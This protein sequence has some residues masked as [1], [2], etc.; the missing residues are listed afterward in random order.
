MATGDKQEWT[1]EDVQNHF[2]TWRVKRPKPKR[3]PDELW[4]EAVGLLSENT[5]TKVAKALRLEGR[6]LKAK[7]VK[8]GVVV[9][10][11]RKGKAAKPAVPTFLVT[12]VEDVVGKERQAQA[13]WKVSIKRSD[14]L[15]MAIDGSELN[16]SV[17]Q[18][19]VNGFCQG[20]A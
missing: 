9:R 3:I 13:G 4:D 1:L 8:A 18:G 10:S 11:R 20:R 5:V 2:S 12:S 16:E 19:L 7:A 17:L 15:E 14:G 6:S